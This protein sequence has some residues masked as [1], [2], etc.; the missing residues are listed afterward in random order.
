MLTT[1]AAAALAL[2]AAPSAEAVAVASS[3]VPAIA[4]TVFAAPGVAPHLVTKTLAEASAVWNDVGITLV[5]RVSQ[6]AVPDGISTPHVVIGDEAGRRRAATDTPIGW[7]TFHRPDEPDQRIHLS[8]RNGLALLAESHGLDRRL[9]RMP[10]AQI[11]LM[12]GRLLGRA[13]AH[14]LGHYLLKSPAHSSEGLMKG[15]RTVL[16][17]IAPERTAFRASPLQRDVVAGRIRALARDD[18]AG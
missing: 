4:V 1:L 18:V 10:P 16:E 7:V 14:E 17:F 3:D 11:D 9:K 8:R 13:L 6:A 12:L 15:R 2:A 5:W